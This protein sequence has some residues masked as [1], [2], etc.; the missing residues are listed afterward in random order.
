VIFTC[1]KILR[2]EA[3]GF[4]SSLKEGWLVSPL[5]INRLCRV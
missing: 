4:T 3:S 2:L 1:R 5:K